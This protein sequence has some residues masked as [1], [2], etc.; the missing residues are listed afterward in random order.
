M[1]GLAVGTIILGLGVG[2]LTGG[3]GGGNAGAGSAGDRAQAGGST[4][5]ALL[6][7]VPPVDVLAPSSFETASFAFG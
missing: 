7:D 1:A 3:C 2:G 5:A 4:A 6:P